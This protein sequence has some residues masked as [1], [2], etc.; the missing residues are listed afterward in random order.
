MI[1]FFLQ[2]AQEENGIRID[3]I[4]DKVWEFLMNYDYPG[5]IRELKN[6]LD[7]MV[8]LSQN[9]VITTEGIPILY[10][11]K[12]MAPVSSYATHELIT[13]KEFKRRSEREYLEWAL[14]QTNWNVS[15]A[16]RELSIS[17]RQIF[18]KINEYNIEKPF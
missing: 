17:T 10:N 5:N 13:W 12:R 3:R 9:H 7:R 6:T 11:L 4:E 2:K 15:A 8:V 18:N 16:A 1:H 14:R